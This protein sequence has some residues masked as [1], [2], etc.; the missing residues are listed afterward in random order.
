MSRNDAKPM[1]IVFGGLPGTGKTTLARALA[2]ELGAI[3]LRID[4]IEQALRSSG[5]TSE[6]IGASGYFV[7]YA[8]AESNLRL[9]TWVV[10]DSANPMLITRKAWRGVAEKASAKIV[11]VEII[12]SDKDEHRVR[13]ESRAGNFPGLQL[14]TWR[15]ITE[16]PFEEWDRD[17]IVIDTAHCS[18]ELASVELARQIAALDPRA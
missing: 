16:R 13:V 10:A 8:L 6:E 15:E 2:L 1:L 14:P 3:Y 18:P 7:A 17:R 12:C 4:E 11:E 9:G 5:F